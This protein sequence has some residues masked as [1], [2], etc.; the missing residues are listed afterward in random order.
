MVSMSRGPVDGNW[1]EYY[2]KLMGNYSFY[3]GV[4]S[5]FQETLYDARN[6][7]NCKPVLVAPGIGQR[8]NKLFPHLKSLLGRKL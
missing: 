3:M 5:F 4:Q 1:S 8:N 2:T 7:R 6:S